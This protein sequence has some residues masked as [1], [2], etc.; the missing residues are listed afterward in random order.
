MLM[1]NG[2]KYEGQWLNGM[3]DGYGK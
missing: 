2:T 3:R 1:P